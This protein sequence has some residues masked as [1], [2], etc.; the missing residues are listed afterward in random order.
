LESER[1]A[2]IEYGPSWFVTDFATTVDQ[3]APDDESAFELHVTRAASRAPARPEPEI[4]SS[5]YP[6]R[7]RGRCTER[8]G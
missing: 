6:W 7:E 5:W 3:G 8:P 2:D 1:D 4:A